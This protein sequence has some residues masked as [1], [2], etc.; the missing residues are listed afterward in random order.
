MRNYQLILVALVL[1]LVGCKTAKTTTSSIV[2]EENLSSLRPDLTTEES[3]K[4]AESPSSKPSVDT[5]KYN[6]TVELDS[7]NK[8]MIARNQAIRY[9]DG[10]TIQIYTGN[11]R[12]EADQAKTQALISDPSLSPVISYYQPSY[13]VKVGQYTT[14]LEAHKTYEALKKQFPR[15]LLVPERIRVN[16]E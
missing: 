10:Y 13:K 6:I 3:P 4:K 7:V 5:E 16:Y 12:D 1:T 8:T 9:R 11:S 15:A 14:R 2:Y